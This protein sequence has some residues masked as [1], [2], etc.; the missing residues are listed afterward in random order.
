MDTTMITSLTEF[1]TTLI[2][3]VPPELEGLFYILCVIVLLF[4][5][6]MFFNLLFVVFGVTKW[7]H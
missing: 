7:R 3:E 1:F 5:I 4:I 6:N 2:G